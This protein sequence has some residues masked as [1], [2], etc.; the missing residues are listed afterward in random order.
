MATIANQIKRI[1][2]SRDLLRSRGKALGL[3]VPAG[4]YWDDKSN[5][6]KS[7]S[8]S[9]LTE[10][11]QIDKIA[12][13][14]N[15]V[16]L[17]RD[18]NGK[19][20]F[21]VPISVRTDGENTVVETT[22]LPT[23]YYDNTIIVPYVKIEQVE[24]IVINVEMVTGRQLSKQSDTIVP[25]AGFNYMG[26]FGYTIV[27]GAISSANAGFGDDYVTAKVATS[28][29][30]DK[31]DTQTISVTKSTMTQKIGTGSA[32]GIASGATITPDPKNDITLSIGKG[33]FGSDRTLTVKSV[34]SQTV[35]D[36]TAPD[37][38]SGKTAWVNG[39]KLTGSMPNYG[40]TSSAEK[41]TAAASFNSYNGK[42][43]I[44]PALGYYNDYSTITTDIVYNP[45]RVFNTTNNSATVTDTMS[46][47]VY[48]ETIPAGYYHTAITRKI[49]VQD[50]AGSVVIDYTNHKA[51][52]DVTKAGW[53]A[54]D[55]T[56]D[57]S[58]GPAVYVQTEAD[59]KET[60]HAFVITPAKDTDGK[61]TSYLTQVTVDNTL[62]FDMLA[63]I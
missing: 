55:V 56:V 35:A 11:D 30:L 52:F 17:Y 37:I 63:A 1:A 31:D 4:Q 43:A 19:N 3:V 15:T 57:I 13:A 48:Y 9:A 62:I 24:D 6:Y 39:V 58:A 10:T 27:D 7:Y 45:T 20:E 51:T 38:L 61:Q 5:T 46:A 26:Q 22:T 53:I 49:E 8:A 60:D 32:T 54:S 59:L 50:Y 12:A 41:Y 34:S 42:L 16:N 44:Q 23:G 2:D 25:S 28:G 18:Q 29:W 36:A 33:I 21:R 14:F 40:G 47:K